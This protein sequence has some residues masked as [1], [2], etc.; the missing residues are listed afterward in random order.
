MIDGDDL[1]PHVPMRP[2]STSRPVSR[3][4]LIDPAR[5]SVGQ[6]GNG[7]AASSRPTSRQTLT[8]I[9]SSSSM[10]AHRRPMSSCARCHG[11]ND[12]GDGLGLRSSRA[13][14]PDL[15]QR[16]NANVMA[17]ISKAFEKGDALPVYL[18]STAHGAWDGHSIILQT[19]SARKRDRSLIV[20][21]RLTSHGK[22]RAMPVGGSAA[23][24]PL[25]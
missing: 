4:E 15:G 2:D 12:L 25:E 5:M 1:A 23:Q 14:V 19:P 16:A 6:A 17:C 8:R 7:A 3:K 20:D 10:E 21:G 22:E 11:A 9:D 24:A 18:P 13:G